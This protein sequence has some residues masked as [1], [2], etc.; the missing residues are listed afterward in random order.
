MPYLYDIAEGNVAGH[1][2]FTKIGYNGDVGLALEDI[3]SAGGSYPWIPAGGIALDVVS[4]SADDTIDGTGIQKVKVGY[5]DADYTQKSEIVELNG[6][7]PVPLTDTT[8]LRVNGMA[9]AQ[10]GTDGHAAGVITVEN[11]GGAVVYRRIDANFTRDRDI[12]F[13]VPLGKT[14]YITSVMVSSGHTTSGK[15]VRWTG[16][17]QVNEVDSGVKLDFF[18]PYFAGITQDASIQKPLEMP[19]RIPATADVTMLAS[20]NQAGSFC[21]CVLRGWSENE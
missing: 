21:S 20:S 2:V 5:L 19:I 10:V 14:L 15:V 1:N 9:A 17:A 13:T 3:V 16:R 8:I 11:V 12:A 4:T 7:T 18:L 6:T